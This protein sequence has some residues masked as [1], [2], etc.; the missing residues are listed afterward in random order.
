M[1]KEN[2]INLIN[3]EKIFTGLVT[4]VCDRRLIAQCRAPYYKHPEGCPNWAHKNGCPPNIPYFPNIYSDQVYIAAVRFDFE[5]FLS[6]RREVH[7]DW[8]ERALRNPRHW[9]GHV[10]S[11]LRHF[12]FDELTKNELLDGEILFN[13]EAM[14]VNVFATCE[15]AGII[16]EKYPER[17]VYSV[18]LIANNKIE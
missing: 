13:P 2:E 8:T 1:S 16:L 14:G 17:F 12:L 6:S 18:A 15:N 4:A 3:R 5:S 9:Q 7:P 11:E 10:R